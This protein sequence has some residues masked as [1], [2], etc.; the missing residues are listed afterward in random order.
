MP[1][2][3][4]P[5]L[6]VTHLSRPRTQL[7]ETVTRRLGVCLFLHIVS[8]AIVMQLYPKVCSSRVEVALGY[9]LLLSIS[10]PPIFAAD[11]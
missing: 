3:N 2:E 1:P 10:A 9:F 11:V 8:A 6:K 4:G 7:N 5:L